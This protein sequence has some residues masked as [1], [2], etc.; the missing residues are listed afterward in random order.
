METTRQ[1][2]HLLLRI[3]WLQQQA[4]TAAHAAS[5]GDRGRRLGEHLAN[6]ARA[7]DGVVAA[8][9]DIQ[10]SGAGNGKA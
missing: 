4:H 8:F 3:D 9:C 1:I 10:E 7:L 6:T 5:E 2:D